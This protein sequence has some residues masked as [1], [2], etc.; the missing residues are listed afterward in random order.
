MKKTYLHLCFLLLFFISFSQEDR[1]IIRSIDE[2]NTS[3]ANHLKYNRIAESFNEFSKSK[4]LS[5]SIQ[6]LYGYAIAN[7]N[8]GNIYSL[9][10]NDESAQQSYESMLEASMQLND[11][12]LIGKSYYQLGAHCK[13]KRIYNQS[14]YYFDKGL[15][16]LTERD[17]KQ[18][19]ESFQ[20]IETLLFKIQTNLASAYI[21]NKQFERALI[22]LLRVQ[23]S[24]TNIV[25]DRFDEAYFNYV[26]GLYSL[27]VDHFKNAELRFSNAIEL[28]K[29]DN[30]QKSLKLLC[31]IYK[32]LSDLHSK[33][34]NDQEAYSYILL[35]NSYR[36]KYINEE[37]VKEE[38]IAKSKFSIA[39]YKFTADLADYNRMKQLEMTQKIKKI[40]IIIIVIICL[41]FISL[42]TLYISYSSKRKLAEALKIKNKELE[43]AT[44]KALKSSELKS[45]FISNVS[46]ELRT[47]LYGVVGIT[48]L[49]LN[50]MKNLGARDLKYL[51]SLKYSGDY[52][53]SLVNDILQVN[54]MEAQK[55]ELKNV[56]V[57]LE[58]L[59]QHIKDSFQYRLQESNNKIVT[60]I[61]E[62]L[63]ENILC[64][65]V[66]LSQVLINLVGNS[67][68]FT[69]SGTIH[70]R[71]KSLGQLGKKV[72]LR[73]EVEDNGIGIPKEKFKVIFENFSQLGNESNTNYQGTGLGLSITKNIIEL[74]DSKIEL[75]S[76]VNKGTKFSFDVDFL[77][78]ESSK[79]VLEFHK[80][81]KDIQLS[82]NKKYRILVAEDNKI[83]QIVTKSL[84]TKQ[85]YICDIVNNGQEALE[86][87]KGNDYDL[88]L[89]DINMPVMNGHE[90]TKAIR[91]F[92][93]DIPIIA[94]TAADIEEIREDYQG[95]GF[96][97]II[98]KPFDNYEFFQTIASHIQNVKS[99]DVT[100]TIAS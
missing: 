90:T 63:P 54:K 84:L 64:D 55:I 13:N 4:V 42:V 72:K 58:S 69:E 31:S 74:L 94:L 100:L 48:S 9:M 26:H 45:K 38:I 83:N 57:N 32:Q 70:L 53:L 10:Q 89:M 8:L 78:D 71:I 67:I 5:D 23:S 49:L 44:L 6:D 91:L 29:D 95:N 41:L 75:E 18:G 28:L 96:N 87:I 98:T 17:I 51:K 20:V 37:K 76:E 81:E 36:D 79:D 60:S 30:N 68:K 27:N 39:E 59:A 86:R 93:D 33:M 19:E 50:D 47:P 7:Y 2:L 15:Q 24:I 22:I 92:N 73:F 34:D 46:H 3:A 16:Y 82:T 97:D 65:K 80:K 62:N 14:I 56:S 88:I 43:L 11:P 1:D 12:E 66:R 25:L 85:N 77:V 61:D 40:N 35:Y 52:L 99:K 21:E